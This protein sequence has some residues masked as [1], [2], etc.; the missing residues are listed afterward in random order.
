MDNVTKVLLAICTI[1]L[2][3]ALVM[4][5]RQTANIVTAGGKAFSGSLTAAGA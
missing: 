2:V 4:N 3:S 5:G 1:G